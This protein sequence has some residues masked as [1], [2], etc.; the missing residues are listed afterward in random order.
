[1]LKHGLWIAVLAVYALAVTAYVVLREPEAPEPAA[2]LERQLG[3]LPVHTLAGEPFDLSELW[4]DKPLLV[5]ATSLSCPL[6]RS[7]YPR[8]H[9]LAQAFAGRIEVAL[10]YTIEAHPNDGTS[11]YD[12]PEW[13]LAENA[14]DG[15]SCAQPASLQER[16]ALARDYVERFGVTEPVYLDTMDNRVWEL[17]GQRPNCAVLVRQDGRVVE[18]HEWFDDLGMER[19][20]RSELGIEPN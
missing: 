8:F 7:T 12:E 18:R 10:L 15:I 9:R 20:L 19:I 16:Q 14:R 6:S 2:S 4:S 5:C 1:M 13:L 11:P 17:L 3:T